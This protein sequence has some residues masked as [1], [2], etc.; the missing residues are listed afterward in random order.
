MK[1]GVFLGCFLCLE[2]RERSVFMTAFKYSLVS[3]PYKIPGY[4]TY[5]PLN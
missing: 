3:S 1:E 4:A 2:G 5:L